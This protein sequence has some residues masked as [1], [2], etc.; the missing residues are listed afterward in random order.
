MA[1]YQV[2][3]REM[4][5]TSVTGY[6][7]DN[8]NAKM[9]V[10]L[11]QMAFLV[12][13]NLVDNCEGKIFRDTLSISGING[14]R[15]NKLPTIKSQDTDDNK[16]KGSYAVTDDAINKKP[17]VLYNITGIVKKGR[18]TIAY[19]TDKMGELSREQVVKDAVDDKVGNLTTQMY[20]GNVLLRGVG[21][22][23][24][25]L[26]IRQ[27]ESEKSVDN[28]GTKADNVW[29]STVE[30]V[31][32]ECGIVKLKGDFLSHNIESNVKRSGRS[33]KDLNIHLKDKDTDREFIFEAHERGLD[34]EFRCIARSIPEDAGT[35]EANI[36]V[37]ITNNKVE[38]Q[39]AILCVIDS[40]LEQFNMT[41]STNASDM[42]YK[43]THLVEA[44]S[45]INTVKREFRR[46]Q[47]RDLMEK[48]VGVGKGDLSEDIYNK[49][50]KV[51]YLC[52][53]SRTKNKVSFIAEVIDDYSKEEEKANN[54]TKVKLY[55]DIVQDNEHKV[56]DTFILEQAKY[57]RDNTVSDVITRFIKIA[58]DKISNDKIVD[59]NELDRYTTELNKFRD[60]I[61]DDIR[62]YTTYFSTDTNGVHFV[63]ININLNTVS[64]R[65]KAYACKFTVEPN[66]TA[67][68]VVPNG[69]NLEASDVKLIELLNKV[70]VKYKDKNLGDALA[71][72][73]RK[74]MHKLYEIA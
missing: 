58:F 38:I 40:A 44:M 21:I 73:V 8:G 54:V 64:G 66:G 69:E 19:D 68:F 25:S 13:R 55:I 26:P 2:I 6:V 3:A 12:G 23:I 51:S 71:I 41:N 35:W 74:Y 50:L 16:V 39:G 27:I 29:I 15:L 34:G 20:N 4:K 30:E 60:N 61:G 45:Y 9:R 28:K 24:K 57:P 37:N 62:V 65:H 63:D 48:F 31:F 52:G 33:G 53:N 32:K 11:D 22:N 67:R 10:D 17:E 18:V 49:G 42:K 43:H 7:L 70:L 56:T 47:G 59:A 36:D 72:S 1:N 5:G 46:C 14:L